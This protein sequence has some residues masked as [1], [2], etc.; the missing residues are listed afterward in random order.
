[1]HETVTASSRSTTRSRARTFLFGSEIKA[2]LAHPAYRTALDRRAL[3]EYFT[4]QN[5]FTDRTLFEGIRLLPAGHWLR[6]GADG[7]PARP[8]RY[9]DFRFVE[10]EKPADEADYVDELDRL[11][12]QAVTRQLV[13]DV[14]VG[15]YLSGGVDSGS[16]TAVAATELP[17]IRTFTAGFDL[18]LCLRHR[19]GLRRTRER[20]AHVLPVQD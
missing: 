3:L 8:T 16:I 9:W 20:R 10:P 7:V 18:E 13:S 2:I 19:D 4:F 1:M 15:A 14:E 17:Y 12:R 5:L 6:L 11:F